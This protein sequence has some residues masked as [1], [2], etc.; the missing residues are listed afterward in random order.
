MAL[1]VITFLTTI[2]LPRRESRRNI[3]L[4]KS[5]SMSSCLFA[6]ILCEEMRSTQ[7]T[8]AKY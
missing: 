7:E 3:D 4:T 2:H 5:Q 1:A 6:I 8:S